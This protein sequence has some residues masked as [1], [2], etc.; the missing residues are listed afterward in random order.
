MAKYSGPVV[1]SLFLLV[2]ACISNF[3]PETGEDNDILVVEGLITD[4]SRTTVIKIS[5]SY[6]LGRPMIPRPV[7]GCHVTI[8]DENHISYDLKETS[9]GTYTI[10]SAEF[11]GHIGGIYTL[12]IYSGSRTYVSSP[13]K[14]LP[15]PPVDTLFFEKETIVE[16]NEWGIPEEGCRIY[17]S[18]YDRVNECLFYR[19]DFTETWEFN[20][21]YPVPNNRCWITRQSDK[22]YIK[23]TS[24]YNQAKVT[25][26][27]LIFI[28]NA[29]DRLNIKY[30]ILVN[31]YS[32]NEKEYNY[33]EKLQNVSE[34]VGG[35]YDVSPMTITSNIH[36]PN[37][38]E[39]IVLG[40]FSVS[41]VSQK[42]LFIKESFSG[43]PSLYRYNRCFGDTIW[44]NDTIPGLNIYTWIIEDYIT[45]KI[46]T[47]EKECADC[48]TRGSTTKPY[49]WD[50]QY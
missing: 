35:L 39:E 12:R 18:T 27:P 33:W 19:W 16:E 8:T 21:P 45:Y 42:R 15:V 25:N 31:Q 40:Y 41:A 29:T 47:R 2:S 38:P 28:S 30:S 50:E 17:L 20:L 36:C 13:V 37:R 32:V 48:T 5:K 4:Q 9:D 43:L 1:S 3:V 24:V 14:M 6:P 49:F 22:I 44:G 23:N 7:R 10:D 11:Q 26:F 34:N 46:T